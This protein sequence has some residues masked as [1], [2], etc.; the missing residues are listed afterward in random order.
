MQQDKQI[1]VNCYNCGEP[2]YKSIGLV[3]TK[4]LEEKKKLL[5]LLDIY[6]EELARMQNKEID[7]GLWNFAKLKFLPHCSI[8]DK[9]FNHN[10]QPI[11]IT[12]QESNVNNA[13]YLLIT[14]D[15][16]CDFANKFA[17]IGYFYN[18]DPNNKHIKI[19]SQLNIIS[20]NFNS[21]E[22]KQGKWLRI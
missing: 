12:N 20:K 14:G 9:D 1:E 8:F 6:D 10:R 15:F 5:I 18:P 19:I 21:F 11:F 3:A 4:I 7:E 13:D 17:K 2:I 22:K 16:S